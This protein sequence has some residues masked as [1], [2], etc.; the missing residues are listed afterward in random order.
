MAV[1]DLPQPR[2]DLIPMADLKVCGEM[3]MGMV[4]RMA[5]IQQQKKEGKPVVWTSLFVPK[6]ILYAMDIPMMYLEVLAG[7][8]SMFQLA[9]YYCQTTEQ[10]GLSRDACAVHRCSLGIG[11][12]DVR[13]L[14]FENA[15][16][17][18]DLV[19]GSNYPCLQEGKAFHF[20]ADRYH[21][22][23]YFIDA[24]VN[25]WGG[26]IPD[27]AAEYY[28]GQLEGMIRFL[29]DHGFK[30][31]WQRLK[32]EVAFT[33]ALSQ[34][35]EEI[36]VLRR[37][38]PT[39]MKAFDSFILATAPFALPASMRK[40]DLIER[41]RD[42]VKERVEKGVGVVDQEKIRLLWVGMPPTCDF[43]LLNYPEQYGAVIA[44]STLEFLVGF[45]LSPRLLDPEEPL[46]SIARAMLAS[47][48][49]PMYNSA[50]D[51]IVQETKAYK[52]DG[53]ICTVERTCS[54]TPGMLRL[55]KDAISRETGLPSIVFDVNGGDEREYD[56]AA[57]KANIDSFIESLLTSKTG[58]QHDPSR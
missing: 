52:I 10:A 25:S 31:H 30:L 34:L 16:T 6:E 8:A 19:V 46:V 22:P 26:E 33:K 28:A 48:S 40:L 1:N 51:W 5:E 38:V 47:P 24:P 53:V 44:K 13:D 58:G 57:A 9:G 43:A 50:I 42:E 55:T 49:N 45:P 39:P 2:M 37:A 7:Q 35:Q 54:L 41:L 23:H 15:F 56:P 20:I 21:C 3:Q 4:A 11:C 36:E 32:E 29:E 17:S 12:A 14:Y 18:P 27:Y